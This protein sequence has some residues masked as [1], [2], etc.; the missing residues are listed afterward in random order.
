MTGLP[1]SLGSELPPASATRSSLLRTAALNRLNQQLKVVLR[2]TRPIWGPSPDFHYCQTVADLLMRGRPFDER[3]VLS[4]TIAVGPRQHSHFRVR[5]SRGDHILPSQNR[6]SP[7]LRARSPYLRVYPPGTGW[8]IY[9]PSPWVP[10]SSPPTTSRAT[11]QV[12]EPTST[13]TST[14]N[15][16]SQSHMATDG[17]SV[18]KSWCRTD[19]GL[20]TRYYSLTITVLFLWGALSDDRTSLSF[21]YAAGPRQCSLPLVRVPW[22][23]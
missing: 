12:F 14:L 3:T 2:P 1:L 18:S 19:L 13:R 10:F 7:N 17:Q 15:C 16:Q 5:V 6:G 23:S 9:S 4:F 20:M 11:V 22:P 8:P 21:V